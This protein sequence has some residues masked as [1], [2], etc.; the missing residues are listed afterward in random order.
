M[1]NLGSITNESNKE[2]NENWSYI[3]N[4]QSRILI[5]GGFW[6]GET[7]AL[8]N[9]IKE[10]DNIDKMYLYEKDLRGTKYEFLIKKRENVGTN[11]F[12]DSNA[13]IEFSNRIDDV[14]QNIDDY[15]P[16]IKRKIVILFDDM[17]ADIMSN[18]K[19]QAII[20]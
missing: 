3:P 5:I 20:K 9:L 15:N 10:Q 19:F 7:N 18:K 12:N 11:H 1:I 14:Y 6:S 4:Y 17:I 2:H 16:R 13:F 8:I